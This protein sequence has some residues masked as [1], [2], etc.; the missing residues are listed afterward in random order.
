M[1]GWRERVGWLFALICLPLG[2]L[3]RVDTQKSGRGREEETGGDKGDGREGIGGQNLGWPGGQLGRQGITAVW[4]FLFCLAFLSFSVLALL[5]IELNEAGVYDAFF[6][7]ISSLFMPAFLLEM[8]LLAW[9]WVWKW[10]THTV[11][12]SII[13]RIHLHGGGRLRRFHDANV[14]HVMLLLKTKKSRAQADDICGAAVAHALCEATHSR[15]FNTFKS[16]LPRLT[17][18]TLLSGPPPPRFIHDKDGDKG[19]IS[20]HHPLYLRYSKPLS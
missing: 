2:R 5:N 17:S 19:N 18:H 14:I 1:D 11:N 10:H 9:H 15:V 4:F 7:S 8:G 20:S 12:R 16:R 13:T 3:W 6:L